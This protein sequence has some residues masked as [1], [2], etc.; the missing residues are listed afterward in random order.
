MDKETKNKV[1]EKIEVLKGEA[2]EFAKRLVAVYIAL[3]WTWVNTYPNTPTKTDIKTTIIRLLND[4]TY[5]I[6]EGLADNQMAYTIRTG[7]I[8]VGVEG[9]QTKNKL[10]EVYVMFRDK[11]EHSILT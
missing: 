2:D 10:I 3:N 4:L 7:G 8:V 1:I 9:L 6:N 5:S 11:I